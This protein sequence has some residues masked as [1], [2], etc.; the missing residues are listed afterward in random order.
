MNELTKEQLQSLLESKAEPAISIYMPA[1]RGGAE[2]QQNPT[3]FK[4]LLREAEDYLK[5]IGQNKQEAKKILQPAWDQLNDEV[6]WQ[7][8][9]D[10][11]ATFAAPGVYSQFQ[12]PLEF[13]EQVYIGSDFHVLPLLDMLAMNRRFYLLTF[14][15]GGVKL[16]EGTR[17]SIEPVDVDDVP[18]NLAEAL[19]WDDPEDHLQYSPGPGAGVGGKRPDP[20]FHG[21]SVGEDASREKK[22]ILRY[23]Q[24]VDKALMEY[25]AGKEIPLVLA[26]VDYLLPIYREAN[27][28]PHILDG[29]VHG[30]PENWDLLTLHEKTWEIIEPHFLEEE[31]RAAEVFQ[32]EY[33]RGTGRVTTDIAE[34]IPA[35]YNGQIAYLFLQEDESMWGTYNW[36]TSQIELHEEP[37]YENRDLLDLVAVQTIMNDG[38]VVRVKAQQ[39]PTD[40][41]V[42]A[43]YRYSVS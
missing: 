1:E 39:L 18:P 3:R 16:Y 7:L 31:S 22:D 29:E 36:Q 15:K 43:L 17:F 10:G 34:I 14:A 20:M 30:S 24:E 13:K 42:A 6:F 4:N 12:V 23:A 28:Y 40:E 35:A 9:S 2:I 21:H 19:K 11:L 8:Q 26:G 5:D 27:S 25:L 38:K 37:L 33:G 41:P 32:Q